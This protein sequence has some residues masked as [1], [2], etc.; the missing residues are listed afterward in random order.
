MYNF[1]YSL[2]KVVAWCR[3]VPNMVLR[4]IRLLIFGDAENKA[5]SVG[6]LEDKHSHPAQHNT[7]TE[8]QD[9]FKKYPTIIF[10]QSLTQHKGAEARM[11]V[12]FTVPLIKKSKGNDTDVGT[13]DM[14][15]A[16]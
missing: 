4:G 5:I 15:G 9:L 11:L 16:K 13:T 3:H 2:L 14:R 10:P 6:L 12:S 7:N 1:N 8:L